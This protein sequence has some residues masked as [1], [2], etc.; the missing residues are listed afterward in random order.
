MFG[1]RISFPACTGGKLRFTFSF[2]FPSAECR[3]TVCMP[4]VQFIWKRFMVI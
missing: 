3:E 4:F 2:T 1:D